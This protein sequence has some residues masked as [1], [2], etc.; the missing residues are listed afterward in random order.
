M[1]IPLKLQELISQPE[2]AILNISSLM[3]QKLA[4]VDCTNIVTISPEQLDIIFTHIPPEW[5]Y[6]EL[7]EIF[8]PKTLTE[9]FSNQL[10]QYIDSG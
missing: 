7:T 9:T 1:K 6:I 8:D 10:G 2:I 4:L 5:D 3:G